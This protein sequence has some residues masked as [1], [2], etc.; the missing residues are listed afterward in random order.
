MV[1]VGAEPDFVHLSIFGSGNGGDKVAVCVPECTLIV[2]RGNVAL[3]VD[4]IGGIG[5]VI[6]LVHELPVL[7]P[8]QHVADFADLDLPQSLV[9]IVVL[10][11]DI[12]IHAVGAAAADLIHTVRGQLKYNIVLAVVEIP[13]RAFD[14]NDAVL[15]QRQFLRGFHF[16]VESV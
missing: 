14:L 9:V 10:S 1:R 8:G 3:R 5:K 7:I 11:D 4:L 13:M 12:V 15:A 6:R 16:A 2:R